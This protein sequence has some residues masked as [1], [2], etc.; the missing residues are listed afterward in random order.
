MIQG[1][2]NLYQIGLSTFIFIG[3]MKVFIWLTTLRNSVTRNIQV[4]IKMKLNNLVKTSQVDF[5]I[6]R[7]TQ[8]MWESVSVWFL[9]IYMCCSNVRAVSLIKLQDKNVLFQFPLF[10]REL[11]KVLLTK[12]YLIFPTWTLNSFLVLR[13]VLDM[14]KHC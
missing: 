7:N 6:R 1:W 13:W 12:L 8:K 9:I 2:K 14:D 11:W 5:L 4:W 3:I 10:S